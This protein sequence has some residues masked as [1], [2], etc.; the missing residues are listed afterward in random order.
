MNLEQIKS[1]I[2]RKK[3]LL[4]FSSVWAAVVSVKSSSVDVWSHMDSLQSG[5]LW[6]PFWKQIVCQWN[7]RDNRKFQHKEIKMEK[8]TRR[9]DMGMWNKQNK[10]EWKG[11]EKIH[12]QEKGFHTVHDIQAIYHVRQPGWRED[13]LNSYMILSFR[14]ADTSQMLHLFGDQLHLP[15]RMWAD[16]KPDQDHKA[17]TG[18]VVLIWRIF[19]NIF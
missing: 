14:S 6:R 5:S 9:W 4:M 2:A 13:L 10:T 3:L 8:L 19:I 11:D 15:V 12:V 1:R 17:S 16:W 7:K 18:F